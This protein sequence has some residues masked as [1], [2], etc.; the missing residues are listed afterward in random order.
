[1]AFPGRDANIADMPDAYTIHPMRL[2]DLDDVLSLQSVGYP[3]AL[4]DGREAFASRIRISPA[5][6][7]TATGPNGLAGYLISHPWSSRSPPPV[8]TVLDR[9]PEGR[10]CW[11]I[12][13]LSVAPSAQ[14]AGLARR[15]FEAGRE[16]ARTLGLERSEL[17]A[18]EGA[19][20]FWRRL[21]YH[22]VV[23]VGEAL[24]AK[25]AGYG[26]AAVYMTHEI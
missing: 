12:H 19:A 7:L 14:G 2:D 21:G 16:A 13:D 5:T 1:M 8:D 11:F 4:H 23:E 9:L 18:V 10:A 15:L 24:A 3:P 17:I 20:P 6:N 22:P 25:V 26:A